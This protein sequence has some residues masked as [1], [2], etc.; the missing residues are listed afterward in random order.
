MIIIDGSTKTLNQR[1]IKVPNV[2]DVVD[3]WLTELNAQL[4]VKEI[5]DGDVVETMTPVT[6]KGMIQP[7][8]GYE[9][10]ILREG[11]RD[12]EWVKIYTDYANFNCDDRLY[13]VDTHYRIMKKRPFE[14]YSYGYDRYDAVLDFVD[15][16]N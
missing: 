5:V 7:L 11:E 9:L 16:E 13:L 2:A 10:S 1:N 8:S 6:F 15:D 12:W 4:V 3:V 14:R